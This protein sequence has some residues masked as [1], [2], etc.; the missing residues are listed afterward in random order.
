MVKDNFTTPMG[1]GAFKETAGSLIEDVAPPVEGRA[2]A[3]VDPLQGTRLNNYEISFILGKGSY[4]AVYKARDVNLGRDVAIKFLHEFLD[5]RHDALFLREAKAIAALGKHP[6]IVQIYEWSEHQGRDYF[7]LEFVGSSAAML[8]KVNPEGL[9]VERALGIA[10]DCAEGLDYA[11]ARNIIHR[12]V[13]PANILLELDGS[14]AK[15]A[16]FGVARFFDAS[17]SSMTDTPGGTPG[18]M[19]PEIVCGGEGDGRSDVFSLGATL[20]EMVCGYLPF[21][22]A[23]VYEVLEKVRTNDRVPLRT[24]RGDLPEVLYTLVDKAT[25]HEA[26]NRY[27]SAGE[28]ATELRKALAF[29]QGTVPAE[30]ADEVS[31]Q[32]ALEEKTRAFKAA[33]DAKHAG[34]AK[35]SHALL[36]KGIEAFRNAEA[37]QHL[38]QFGP[39]AARFV[40]AKAHFLRAEEQA[41]RVMDEVRALKE[42][43]GKMETARQAAENADAP[44]LATAQFA[45]AAEE[46]RAARETPG[47]AGAIKRYEEASVRY[48]RALE[49]AKKSGE[50]ILVAPRR[51][52]AAAR[53]K[54][55]ALEATENAA[56]ETAAAEALAQAAEDALPNFREAKRRYVSAISQYNEAVRVT[57][58]RKRLA[59]E[60]GQRP[61]IKV[62]GIELVWVPPGEFR[63]G[64][65]QGSVEETPVHTVSIRR[66]FWLG[67][68]PVT[69]EQ[70]EAVMGRNPSGFRGDPK[71][72]VENVSWDDC[73]RFIEKINALGQGTFRLPS[74]AEWEYACRAGSEGDWCFGSDPT[75]LNAH[76]W[77]PENAD[78][79]SHPVGEKQANAWGL[80]DMHGNVGEWCED[81]WHQDYHD[82]P[83]T[84]APVIGG[85]GNER[86]TR[87][88]SWCIVAGESRSAYRS[89]HA[90]A[91]MRTDFIG[92]RVCR[93]K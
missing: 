36:S 21:E 52:L 51:A 23:R 49:E 68:Y 93:T 76:A 11:H 47:L 43:R 18:Y 10:L 8:L 27:Q 14:R 17:A 24:R 59:A 66:G 54:A 78:G 37:H 88:G 41:K 89:W 38:R 32:E 29:I 71:L 22:G 4:G 25:A 12:D 2:D 77:T 80:H 75:R 73:Q 90:D 60:Q 91:A 83:D 79:R 46:E 56:D 6:S 74:E 63:M 62:A 65:A 50:A 81:R 48:S 72:P 26:G 35:L 84:A 61:P 92:L 31:E 82:A 5:A 69:Q 57:L 86:V 34:A 44:N 42:A 58:E 20:Y 40:Q 70:W 85:A 19:A 55:H 45:L 87:G 16:D 30:T 39:A 28:M 1:T 3:L 53:Q 67:C 9:A 33:E 64:S 15:L 7:V 13:K